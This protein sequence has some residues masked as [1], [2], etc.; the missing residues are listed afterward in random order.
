MDHVAQDAPPALVGSEQVG[1][2]EVPDDR[3]VGTSRRRGEPPTRQPSP[4]TGP[5]PR[6][7]PG[8]RRSRPGP[9]ARPGPGPGTPG[10]AT[11]VARTGPAGPNRGTGYRPVAGSPGSRERSSSQGTARWRLLGERRAGPPRT[12]AHP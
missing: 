8:R 6:P 4:S 5:G 11:A 1:V 2:E 9:A 12:P 10:A 7:G 3:A